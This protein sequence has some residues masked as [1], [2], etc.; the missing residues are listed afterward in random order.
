MMMLSRNLPGG[1]RKKK[2]RETPVTIAGVAAET[3]TECHPNTYEDVVI[4]P[5]CLN[6][7]GT[8]SKDV[9][10]VLLALISVQWQFLEHGS[11]SSGSV[12]LPD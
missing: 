12:I 6:L 8:E 7:S 11:E 3:R 4:T 2:T 9:D 5:S 1:I 10:W